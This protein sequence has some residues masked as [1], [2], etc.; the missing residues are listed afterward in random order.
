MD[1]IEIQNIEI[2]EF[3]LLNTVTGEMIFHKSPLSKGFKGSYFKDQNT[4]FAV[5]PTRNGPYIFYRNRNYPIYKELTMI[6][7]VDGAHRKFTVAEYGIEISYQQSKYLGFDVWSEEMDID[8]FY[9]ITQSYKNDMFY[10]RY[11]LKHSKAE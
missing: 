10:S 1:I 11:T 5:Y 9:M 7:E 6:L 4:F 2:Y 3:C 8:L